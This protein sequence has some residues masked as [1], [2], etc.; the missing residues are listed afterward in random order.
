MATTRISDVIV[1][2]VFHRY[3]ME[4]TAEKSLFF[5]S[6]II[7]PDSVLAGSLGGGGR[8][9][10]VPFWKDLGNTPANISSD[11]PA[12]LAVTQKIA[13]SKDVAIR[14]NRNQSW[15]AMD[16]AEQLAGDDPMRAI[17]DRVADY[18]N[19]ELQRC[20]IASVKGVQA[21]NVANN[22][23]DMIYS[24][25]TDSADAI[26][27]AERISDDAILDACQTLGDSLQDLKAIGMHSVCYTRLRKQN[28]IDFIPSSRGEV[29]FAQYMGLNVIVDDGLPAIAGTNRVRY[30]TA[31]FGPGAFAW[32]EGMA[33]VPVE[34]DRE[35]L[36]GNGS[37]QDILVSRRQFVLHP[38]G[39][40]WT[41]ASCAGQSP[42]DAELALAANWSRVYERKNVKMALLI[43]N[44]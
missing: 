16:L 22:S 32:G 3:I 40:K 31:L 28:L 25:G 21:A 10:N 42:T 23:S 18:W 11:D 4:K 38:V 41:D 2:E 43:T 8:T 24:I 35:L 14:H 36:A 33:P 37:G 34:T 39:V 5:Q 20:L 29:S 27:D 26:T 7:R 1:P 17:G 44:G 19:R 6:A 9:F 15:S 12:A 13:A 30:T